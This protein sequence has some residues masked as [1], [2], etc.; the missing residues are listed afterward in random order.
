MSRPPPNWDAMVAERHPLACARRAQL[1]R[2]AGQ[3]GE[4]LVV[5][6]NTLLVSAGGQVLS[7][8]GSPSP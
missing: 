3:E 7:E 2:R 1:D 5:W 8:D 4:G 6:F